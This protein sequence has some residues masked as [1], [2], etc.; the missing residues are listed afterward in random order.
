MPLV[1]PFDL[2]DV[3]EII[4]PVGRGN[5]LR[6]PAIGL[7]IQPGEVGIQPALHPARNRP[8][9]SVG[10]HI[11][12]REGMF[13]PEGEERPESET[14]VGRRLEQRIADHQLRT[15]V[16][17]E[18]LFAQHDASH[19]VGDRRSRRIFEIGDVFMPP[20][21]VGSRKTMQ[22]Q[23]ERLAVVQ[24]GFVHRRKQHVGT[25]A[26]VDRGHHQAVILARVATDDG[27]T[28][29]T[30]AAVRGQHLA[31]Q[32][33]LQISQFLLIKCKYRHNCLV[34]KFI[35]DRAERQNQR[36]FPPDPSNRLFRFLRRPDQK[37]F[38]SA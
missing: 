15:V 1:S 8:G 26:V 32:R 7:Q 2:F 23:I 18:Q 14:Y 6:I 35:P 38:Q 30:A 29:V 25:V 4:V 17:P 10:L 19:A 13:V 24:D 31:L 28:H 5:E 22:R 3:F 11:G 20:R 34:F 27:R 37:K 12:M 36:V 21:F 9:A 33:I 16:Y